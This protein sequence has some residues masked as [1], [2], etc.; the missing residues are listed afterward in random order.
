MR[1]FK[2][3]T[4]APAKRESSEVLRVDSSGTFETLLL[5]SVSDEELLESG[6]EPSG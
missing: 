3:S 2:A 6:P 1:L 5:I 4:G